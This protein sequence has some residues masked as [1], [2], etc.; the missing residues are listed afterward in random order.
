MLKC[1]VELRGAA[2][3]DQSDSLLAYKF[4]NNCSFN[5]MFN[6][7]TAWMQTLVSG[8]KILWFVIC[9]SKYI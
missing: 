3:N 9:T 2:E 5:Q 8:A 4:I 6:Q 7:E 1:S